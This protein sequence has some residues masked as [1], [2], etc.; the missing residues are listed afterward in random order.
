MSQETTPE[1]ETGTNTPPSTS[2]E[3][4]RPNENHAR[5]NRRDLLFAFSTRD[6]EGATPKLGGVLGLRSDSTTKKISYD[7]FL[8]K[9]GINVMT[10]LKGSEHI[11]EVTTQ[12]DPDVI[13]DFENLHKPEELADEE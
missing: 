6:V 12:T 3:P 1:P 9:L 8:A 13:G 4:V 10:E 5:H 7:A 2:A 11:V